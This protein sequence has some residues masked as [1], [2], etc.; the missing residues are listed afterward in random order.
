MFYSAKRS[1]G[2]GFVACVLFKDSK[3]STLSMSCEAIPRHVYNSTTHK[4]LKRKACKSG[5]LPEYSKKC[6][7]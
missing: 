5:Y 4:H 3:K 7:Y 6:I 2:K 1:K